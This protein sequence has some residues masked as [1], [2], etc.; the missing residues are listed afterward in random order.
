[1]KRA[2][3]HIMDQMRRGFLIVT[4]LLLTSWVSVASALPSLQ[5]DILGGT[6]DT[7]TETIVASSDSFTLYALLLPNKKAPLNDRYYISAALVPK[8]GASDYGSFTFNGATIHATSD[9]VYGNPPFE[10]NLARDPGDLPRHGI[11]PT[12][13]SEFGFTFDPARTSIPY[14][15]ADDAGAGPTGNGAMYYTAFSV[16]TS[17]LGTDVALHF[18]LYNKKEGRGGAGDVDVKSFAPFSHDAQSSPSVPVP[19]PASL[20]LTALGGISLLISKR[21]IGHRNK[22]S[23]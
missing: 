20:L 11:F 7:T 22:G 19:E 16:N 13:F 18:D 9:M 14:N 3:Y 4:F 23:H 17:G 8:V 21:G 10:S 1:M 6:Y 2:I 15:T 12:F 5:L